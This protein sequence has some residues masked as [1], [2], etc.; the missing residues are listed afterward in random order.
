MCMCGGIAMIGNN[1]NRLIVVCDDRTEKYANYLRQLIST[2]DDKEGEVVGIA[3]GSVE[4]AVWTDKEYIN[5]KSQISSCEHILFMGNSKVCK[6]E[7]SSMIIKYDNY[8]MK[9]GWLGKRAMLTVDREAMSDQLY[10]S[11]ATYC[12][13]YQERY[14]NILII[15]KDVREMISENEAKKLEIDD[16]VVDNNEGV[17]AIANVAKKGFGTVTGLF[18]DGIVKIQSEQEKKDQQYRAVTSVFYLE[19]LADFIEE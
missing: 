4:V 18:N 11:F 9:Y 1:K 10:D 15:K 3:D 14:E 5:N 19:A 13:A 6:K 12:Y 8:G 2:N 16:N 17:N 7:S